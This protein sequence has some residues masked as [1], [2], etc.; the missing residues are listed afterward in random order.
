LLV[1]DVFDEVSDLGVG[2]FL[3]HDGTVAKEKSAK[4][5]SS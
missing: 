5:L 3:S 4:G 1:A 2:R